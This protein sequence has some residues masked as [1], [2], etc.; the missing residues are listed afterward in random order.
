MTGPR[1]DKSL[2][3][4][5]AIRC[6]NGDILQSRRTHD[7]V[8]NSQGY[9]VDGGRSYLRRVFPSVPDYEELSLYYGDP[10]AKIRELFD[11]GSYGK[12][13]KQPL[14]RILLKNL[15]DDHIDAIIRTQWQLPSY[16]HEQFLNEKHWRHEEHIWGLNRD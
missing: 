5:N 2:I 15:T 16:I 3:I 14:R 13:G 6:P 4:V 1:A 12:D 11:W 8:M 10:H 9:G 7:F